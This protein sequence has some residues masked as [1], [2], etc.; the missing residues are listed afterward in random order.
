MWIS[1][2][3]TVGAISITRGSAATSCHSFH[4]GKAGPSSPARSGRG[5]GV[6]GCRLVRAA[7]PD[8]ARRAGSGITAPE[9]ATEIGVGRCPPKEPGTLFEPR[10]R[11]G[12]G[13]ERRNAPPVPGAASGRRPPT[14]T[15]WTPPPRSRAILPHC[16]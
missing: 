3:L 4:V 12:L 15:R 8:G 2:K 14:L 1:I 10:S 9:T 11:G 16:P 5:A 6:P 7:A 13:L